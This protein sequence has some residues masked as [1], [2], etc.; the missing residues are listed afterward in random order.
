MLKLD[1]LEVGENFPMPDFLRTKQGLESV[2]AE[3]TK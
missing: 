3:V 2:D 1:F